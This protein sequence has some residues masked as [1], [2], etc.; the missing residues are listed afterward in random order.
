MGV[1]KTTLKSAL[2]M[3]V[4]Y[5]KQQK[6]K[7]KELRSYDVVKIFNFNT[8]AIIVRMSAD[9][10]CNTLEISHTMICDLIRLPYYTHIANAQNHISTIHC[11]PFLTACQNLAFSTTHILCIIQ[12][13]HVRKLLFHVHVPSPVRL[14]AR[15]YVKLI[16]PRWQY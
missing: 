16:D 12:G 10:L 5:V 2:L 14:C 3:Q 15:N 6:V 4:S 1:K 9:D 13:I 11:L 7:C 8:L